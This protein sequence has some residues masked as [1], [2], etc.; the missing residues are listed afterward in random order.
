VSRATRENLTLEQK[1]SGFSHAVALLI[2]FNFILKGLSPASMEELILMVDF[3]FLELL[4]I[5]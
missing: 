5:A 1:K 3:H 4:I 2:F